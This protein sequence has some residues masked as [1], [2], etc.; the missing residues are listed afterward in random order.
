LQVVVQNSRNSKSDGDQA[1][2]VRIRV[3]LFSRIECGQSPM[4]EMQTGDLDERRHYIWYSWY[5][6]HLR[7][8]TSLQN[9][10]E[11]FEQQ[12]K[13]K[14]DETVVRRQVTLDT[15]VAVSEFWRENG[16]CFVPESNRG[17]K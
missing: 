4:H 10:Y 8:H 17:S 11:Q 3:G 5:I 2:K 16:P 13:I 15:F 1:E 14:A 12:K 9:Q 6:R 7:Q